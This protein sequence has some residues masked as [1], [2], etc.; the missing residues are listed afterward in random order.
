M[1][2]IALKDFKTLMEFENADKNV[3]N[4]E[5]TDVIYKLNDKNDDILVLKYKLYYLNYLAD[6]PKS[7]VFDEETSAV[8]KKYQTDKNLFLSGL[9]D[10]A[11]FDSISNEQIIYSQ[12]K[13]GKE[14]KDLQLILLY[15]GYLDVYPSGYYGTVTTQA[16]KKYQT[17]NNLTVSGKLD[18][19]TQ[20]SLK[21]EKYSFSLG[22]KSNAILEMQKIL[23]SM[24]YLVDSADGT[25][26]DNTKTAVESFQKDNNLTVSGELDKATIDMLNSV[27]LK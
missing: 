7:N 13:T 15:L 20:Q 25:F 1:K 22:Q 23:I 17:D 19:K 18:I 16:V 5:R 11:T 3:N 6:E 10:K 26:D 27:K 21:N 9:I 2:A 14:I 8:V 12:G 4:N 24:G